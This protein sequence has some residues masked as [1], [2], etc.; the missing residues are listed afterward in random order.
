MATETAAQ[1]TA[2]EA[3]EQAERE[4]AGGEQAGGEHPPANAPAPAA[5]DPAP[6]G[7]PE[8]VAQATD[9]TQAGE[10]NPAADALAQEAVTTAQAER[11]TLASRD[12]PRPTIG[13]ATRLAAAV[14]PALGFASPLDQAAALNRRREEAARRRLDRRVEDRPSLAAAQGVV[15]R[16]LTGGSG[17][18]RR[19]ALLR[20][21]DGG[22]VNYVCP[23]C[24]RERRYS[25]FNAGASV[26]CTCGGDLQ[27]PV[28][29]ETAEFVA[30]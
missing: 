25:T 23:A 14:D 27:V 16:T 4:Q 24:A 17:M 15:G 10:G 22:R 29:A 3:R 1:R 18:G 19:T 20:E 13:D 8:A 21:L 26:T 30:D 9:A 2:R 5:T 7:D 28:S 12:V 6:P 11:A